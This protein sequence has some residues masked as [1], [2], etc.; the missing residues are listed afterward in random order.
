MTDLVIRGARWSTAP[1]RRP[2]PPTWRSTTGASPRSAG[3]TG[4]ATREIDADGL[5]AHAGLG[6]HPH[7]LRRPGHLGPRGHARRAGT[8][9]RPSS[10]ATAASASPRCGPDG[11]D[12]LIELME[13]VED[14]PGT[15]LHEGIDWRW[16]SFAEYLD[17]LDATPRVLDVVAQVPHA[18]LRAYVMG[19]RAHEEPTARRDRADGARS[20]RRPS[21]PARPASPR[22]ARS[23]TARSTASC[24]APSAAPDELLAIGDAIG[25]A[26]H[27]VFQLVSDEQGGGAERAWLAEVARRTGA[28]VTYSLAQTPVRARRV[29]RLRS[30][31]P[32]RLAGEGLRIVPQVP[33]R[34]TGM[35]FGLQS[36]LH[37][38]TTH[39]T[40][41]AL[42]DRPLAERVAELRRP[43][44]RGRAAGRGAGHGQP[45]RDRPHEPLGPD[46]PARR[47]A[48]LRAAGR[49]QRRPPRRPRLG[50]APAGGRPR[51]AARAGRRGLPVRPAGQLRGP[52]PRGDPDDDRPPAD[53]ARPVRRRRPLRADLRRVVPH[54]PAHP[55]GPRP[56]PRRPAGP[57]AGRAPA[58]RSHRGHLRPDRPRHASSPASGP[59]STSSTS[60]ACACTPPR[61]ST[62][63]PPAAAA[64]CSGSTATGPPSWPARS[65]SRTASP[66]APAPGAWSGPRTGLNRRAATAAKPC[67]AEWPYGRWWGLR[68]A[69]STLRRAPFRRI[70]A[71]RDGSRARRARGRRDAVR[72]QAA[73]S[74][75]SRESWDEES[76]EALFLEADE[77]S[78][79]LLA[80]V[81][82]TVLAGK[83]ISAMEAMHALELKM[84]RPRRD[85]R[86]DRRGGQGGQP[87]AAASRLGAR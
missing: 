79:S 15:A 51:L 64:S 26:G 11:H 32:R 30:T 82:R 13:G 48:G 72:D 65:P 50:V 81:A 7:P 6:R 53:R 73:S 1:V 19:E 33:C 35:L 16:E 85:P 43:E 10:W 28:T 27:G 68:Y 22:R 61:W 67:L 14:I 34:P 83:E 41:R 54:L 45:G 52:R 69:A 46:V 49:R 62:T 59:T 47:P 87:Q 71:V 25:R 57:R 12:F 80:V 5:V 18:A 3:S 2:A 66:P 37:P 77:G 36:S 42:A 70:D 8:G 78:R 60:T 17:A 86:P 55:L 24:P 76:V 39:P 75:A 9:S 4:G 31:T 84:Q 40:M 44:V 63:C 29:A 38:F 74:S 58:D 20:S 21:T 56:H 23:C